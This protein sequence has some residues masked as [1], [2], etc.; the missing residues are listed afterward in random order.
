MGKRFKIIDGILQG[1]D[2][3]TLIG[4]SIPVFSQ[5]HKLLSLFT[6]KKTLLFSEIFKKGAL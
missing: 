3:A 2:D 6:A 1:I 4:F 5:Y